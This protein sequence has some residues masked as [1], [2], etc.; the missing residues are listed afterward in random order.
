MR[1]AA[2]P[3]EEKVDISLH[4]IVVRLRLEIPLLT[5]YLADDFVVMCQVKETRQHTIFVNWID[6]SSVGRVPVCS[7]YYSI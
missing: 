7:Y 5:T 1:M 6:I 3:L 2:N 4:K